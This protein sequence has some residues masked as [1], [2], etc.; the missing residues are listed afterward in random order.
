MSQLPNYLRTHRKRLMLSQAEVSFLLGA[1]GGA[2]T[3]RYEGFKQV[4]TLETAL[5]F[6]A[7]FQRPISELFAGQYEAAE[8]DVAARAK[9]LAHRTARRKSKAQ[10]DHKR[11][12]LINIAN[13]TKN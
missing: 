7:I 1:H 12:L 13:K 11:Q 2:K 4:P 8:R 5:A 10:I 6:E 9:T 3:S